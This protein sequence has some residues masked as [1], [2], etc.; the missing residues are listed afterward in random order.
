M[1]QLILFYILFLF[2]TLLL[3]YT[4][5]EKYRISILLFSSICFLAVLSVSAT[6]FAIFFIILNY[7][8][9]ILLDKNLNNQGLKNKI[10]WTIILLNISL[11]CFYKFFN[12]ISTI[13]LSKNT[14]VPQYNFTSTFLWVI[15]IG[16]S[17]YTFQA[18]G[19]IIR[20]NRRSEKAMY[21]IER[22]SLYLI[23]FPKLISGPVE[24]SNHFF[25]QL[26]QLP[27]FNKEI[28]AQGLRLFLLGLFKKIVI[29]DQLHA[30]ILAVYNNVQ[31]FNG[32]SLIIVFLF[33]TIFIYA[34]FSGYTDMALGSAKMFGIELKDNFNRPFLAKTVSD[35]WK[36][37]HISLSSWCN[38]FIYNPFIVKYRKHGNKAVIA[39]LF[40]TFVIMGLWHGSNINYVILGILQGIAIVYETYTKNFRIK[41]AS[42]YNIIFINT[43]SRIFVFVFM[44]FSMIF[45]FSNSFSDS[46][47][48]ITHLFSNSKLNQ[49]AVLNMNTNLLLAI[50]FFSI[51]FIFQTLIEKGFDLLS[52]FLKQPFIIRLSFYLVIFLII[53]CFK[54]GISSF[55]YSRF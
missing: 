35:Y 52:F 40:I 26:N 45:F 24:R 17:Y 5:P 13:F 38:D 10:F 25:P 8:F 16:L 31:S 55:Y 48:F 34:D 37:W 28:V 15:P 51:L 49:Y 2:L 12:S 36:R 53:Y 4:L 14:I 33:Q 47:Y 1:L 41:I 46:I 42:K 50:F 3:Y 11:L 27:N 7:Y 30:P 29:A 6:V 19:Y 43:I 44:S 23:F 21:S 54:P 22:F 9:G 32:F 20:I 18:L 39:G